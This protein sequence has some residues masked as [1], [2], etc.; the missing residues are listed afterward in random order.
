MEA[1]GSG[2]QGWLGRC[3]EP[4]ASRQPPPSHVAWSLVVVVMVAVVRVGNLQAGLPLWPLAIRRLRLGAARRALL[5]E[6]RHE[7]HLQVGGKGGC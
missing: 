1:L 5:E 2:L 4:V 6:I 3:V 7:E